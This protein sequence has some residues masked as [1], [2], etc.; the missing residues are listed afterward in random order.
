[1]EAGQLQSPPQSVIVNGLPMEVSRETATTPTYPTN[2]SDSLRAK[3]LAKK[4]AKYDQMP[5]DNEES[6][7]RIVSYKNKAYDGEDEVTLVHTK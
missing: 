7:P 4:L 1:M 6:L 5:D 2:E 3:K